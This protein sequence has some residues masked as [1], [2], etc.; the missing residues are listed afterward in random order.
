MSERITHHSSRHHHHSHTH[1]SSH[2]SGGHHSRQ[3]D[4]GVVYDLRKTQVEQINSLNV[5]AERDAVRRLQFIMALAGTV[6]AI[7]LFFAAWGRCGL[8]VFKLS[9]LD[10]ALLGI[11]FLWVAQF[12]RF[13][14]KL[15][16]L[17]SLIQFQETRV[18]SLKEALARNEKK[19]EDLA[20]RAGDSSE[21]SKESDYR[22]LS[23]L[24]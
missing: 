20:K 3:R 17:K 16:D 9:L 10:L 1:K 22:K 15:L 8:S 7:I 12:G 4:T 6:A 2:S 11:Y 19:L 18:D 14:S 24:S 23:G 5:P 21:D 13:R